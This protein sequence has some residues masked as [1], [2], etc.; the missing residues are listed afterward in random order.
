MAPQTDIATRALVV[1]LMSPPSSKSSVETA[2]LTGLSKRQVN[3]ILAK[4]IE[5]GFDLNSRP[6]V[7]RN[8]FLEDAPRSGRPRIQTDDITTQII[9]K[10]TRDRYGREKTCADIAGELSLEGIEISSLTVLRILSKAGYKKTKPTRKP[11]LTKKMKA[12]RLQWCLAH[13]HWT[14]EDWKNVIWSD[15]TSIVLLH[16]RGGYRVWRTKEEAFAKSCI[17]ERWKGAS[18]FMFWGCFSYDTKGPCY[19]WSPETAAEKRAAEESIV[20]INEALKTEM[21]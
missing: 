10:V 1:A 12:D 11:G 14:L 20:K 9:N 6:L 19:A 18:E 21:N 13:R 3:R 15:E 7:L 16:R 4:A 2:F 8:A 17:R 5:R